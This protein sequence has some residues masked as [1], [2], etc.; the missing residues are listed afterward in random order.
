MTKEEFERFLSLNETYAQNNR[1]KSSDEEVLQ[2]YAYILEYENKD[3]DW[4]N[5][6]H[7]TTDIMYMIKNGKKDILEKIKQDI[8]NWTSSQTELFVQTLISNHLR[9][10]K[11]NERLEFYL[12]LF[13][14][15][16]PDCD[17]HNIFYD[18]LYINLEL[19]EREIIEKLAK[20]LNYG[21]A[22]ELLRIH[23]RIQ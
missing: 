14:T 16:K 11:V 3:S 13:E 5:E 4:W 2:I 1:T 19:A 7:G 9:D 12:E 23:K 10:F 17:L 22:E 20:N 15:L 8:P 18:R 6:D 21:S